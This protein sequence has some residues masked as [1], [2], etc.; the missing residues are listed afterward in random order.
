MDELETYARAAAGLAGLEIDAAWWPA[1]NRHL[2]VLLD[3]AAVV[4][5]ADPD[6]GQEPA[7]GA[8]RA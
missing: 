5:A 6:A 7:G 4:E 3:R 8:A 1:V 2:G